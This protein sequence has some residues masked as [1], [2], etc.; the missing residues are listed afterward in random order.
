ML[1]LIH[2]VKEKQ[3]ILIILCLDQLS[4]SEDVRC[5][6]SIKFTQLVSSGFRVRGLLKLVIRLQ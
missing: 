4:M 1:L 6:Q 3:A 2:E 5:N